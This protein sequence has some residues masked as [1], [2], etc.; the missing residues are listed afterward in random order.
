ML[1][2][3]R[4]FRNKLFVQI[5]WSFSVNL[6]NVQNACLHTQG[7]LVKEFLKK[8]EYLECLVIFN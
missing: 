7:A 5:D 1:L 8:N 3:G 4:I 6:N 2:P